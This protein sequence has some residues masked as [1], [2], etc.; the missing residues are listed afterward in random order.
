MC[1]FYGSTPPLLYKYDDDSLVNS[2]LFVGK[3]ETI[4]EVTGEIRKIFL[5]HN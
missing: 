2:L 3:G 5:D 1:V 4:T